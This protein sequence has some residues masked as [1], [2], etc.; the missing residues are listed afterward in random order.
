MK[1]IRSF[2]STPKRTAITIACLIAALAMLGTVTV[3]AAGA[4]AESSSI[5]AENAQ[6]FAFAD[7]GVDPVSAEVVRTEFDFEQGQF[8][9]EVEFIA[10]GSRHEYW[11]KA[12]DGAVVKKNVEIV[13]T[14]GMNATATAQI[15]MD[16][17]KETALKDAG[18]EI[19][20]VTFTKTKLDLDDGVSVYD[21][22]FYAENVEYDY[23]IDANT[24][25][26]YSKAKETLPVN[27]NTE[28]NAGA[29]NASSQSQGANQVGQTPTGQAGSNNAGNNTSGNQS[30][31]QSTTKDI[32]LEA[33]KSKALAD[34]GVTASAA[35]YTKAKLEYDD[36][37]KL[38]DIAF[39]TSTHKYEYE[40]NA[41]T[42][43]VHHKDVEAFRTGSGQSG[44]NGS[45]GTYIGIDRAKSIAAEHAGFSVQDVTFSKAK[46]EKDD[47]YV[48]YE[49]EFY[50]NGREYEY[51]INAITG[52]ILE[53]DSEWND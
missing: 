38:Y 27:A 34:A 32:G 45:A 33:A 48:L 52:A 35:T 12:S 50:Q 43:A 6:N 8:V 22:E 41:V 5:G 49:I 9:Y 16:E 19:A 40:I 18:L 37:V 36:G 28:N 51:A 2:F 53:Y 23:E 31:G 29:S 11:I 21:L 7:A 44:G 30:S 42:G 25:A 1:K 15:T 10:N 24:G 13:T 4:I 14:E 39:Y 26:I 20:Q 17:A 3:F 47:G 46:L